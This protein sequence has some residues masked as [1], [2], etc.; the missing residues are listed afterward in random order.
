MYASWIAPIS[1]T[2]RR[3]R[4]RVQSLS[5]RFETIKVRRT[6]MDPGSVR[7]TIEKALKEK[8]DPVR[9]AINRVDKEGGVLFVD[10]V[11][12]ERSQA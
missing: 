8:G 3:I 2:G 6:A 5:L 11:Y 9:W 4:V 12:S 10:A 7:D 1:Y